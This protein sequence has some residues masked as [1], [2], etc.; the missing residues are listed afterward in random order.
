MAGREW[1]SD[2]LLFFDGCQVEKMLLRGCGAD[3]E[4]MADLPDKIFT[5]NGIFYFVLPNKNTS[6]RPSRFACGAFVTRIL[7]N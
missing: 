4:S 7:G 2:S 1:F 6:P 3:T 5:R